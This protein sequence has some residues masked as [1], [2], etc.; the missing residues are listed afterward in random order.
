MKRELQYSI[1]VWLF[2]SQLRVNDVQLN[3]I[4]RLQYYSN[5]FQLSS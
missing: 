5:N 3:I 2:D 4:L 1:T